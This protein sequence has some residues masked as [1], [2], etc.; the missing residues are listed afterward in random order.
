MSRRTFLKGAAV[1]AAALATEKI[2][3][4]L[5]RFSDSI[6]FSQKDEDLITAKIEELKKRTKNLAP[7]KEQVTIDQRDDDV[8]G[9]TFEEQ[10]LTQDHVTIDSATKNAIYKTW[11][12]KY[13]PGGSE[14]EK[15]LVAGLERMRPWTSEL[16]R[17]F[18]QY[19]IPEEFIYLS[20]A[21]SHFLTDAISTARAVGPFQIMEST[22]C[23]LKPDILITDEIDER[24]DPIISAEICAKHLRDS[25]DR[26]DDWDLALMDY[27]GGLTNWYA[28]ERGK[29]EEESDISPRTTH[30][31]NTG[32]S[33]V[34]IA[35]KYNTSV[36]LLMRAN[37]LDARK[38]RKLQV[39]ASIVIPQER[40]SLTLE[41]FNEFLEYNINLVIK[42][43]IDGPD[44]VIAPGETISSIA[45]K[46]GV[47]QEMLKNMNN[48]SSDD[49]KI[50][51]GQGLA[52]PGIKEEK[53]KKII[54]RALRHYQENINYPEKFYAIRDV[55]KE[56][57]LDQNMDSFA[58]KSKI[59]RT[60]ENNL[61]HFVY[62]VRS[63][64]TLYG[65]AKKVAKGLNKKYVQTHF[66]H[67]VVLRLLS[68][69][70]QIT[71]PNKIHLDQKLKL[72]I[73]VQKPATLNDMARRYNTSDHVLQRLNPAIKDIDA[74]LPYK[75]SIRI[76]T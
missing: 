30:I 31:I 72:E 53:R 13:E 74:T 67:G 27:N 54:K 65:I 24:C 1:I 71:D 10:I 5:D 37:D 2:L 23:V 60:K 50:I 14:H 42:N 19:N 3:D 28:K 56:H 21:E 36:T 47:S 73:S 44:H 66:S 55:I 68:Q 26:L 17:V 7:T 69:Q 9:K 4:P 45:Q 39:G 46:Y 70:N 61:V 12:N 59:V 64:E 15:G 49:S 51:A 62:T 25:Y 34:A 38:V 32:E 43:N 63:G 22:A 16:K 35:K 8:I 40:E 48:I 58:Q 52:I 18:A 41:G 57:A 33:L 75:Y 6:D 11:R 20:I 76:P 29:K